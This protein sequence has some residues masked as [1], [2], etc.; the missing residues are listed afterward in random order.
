MSACMVFAVLLVNFLY[1]LIFC[2]SVV[3]ALDGK[4][5]NNTPAAGDL[6]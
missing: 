5:K 1:V 6:A 3:V 2:D 4:V